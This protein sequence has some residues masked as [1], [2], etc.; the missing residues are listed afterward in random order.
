VL[1]TNSAMLDVFR[2]VGFPMT[3]RPDVDICHVTMSIAATERYR[4]RAFDR[5]R[6]AAASSMRALFEP[7]VVA[8]IG[9]SH[10]RGRIG[11][12]IFHNLRAS[13]FVGVAIPVNP[14][15]E[16][17]EGIKAYHS[18]TDIPGP[19]DLAVIAVPCEHVLPVADDCIAKGV[20]G[21]VVIS[22]G[23]G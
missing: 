20:K 16:S 8:V 3:E 4:D 18:I 23:F 13:G 15:A 22:A 12:E 14:K 2:D 7:V 10:M 9:A 21:L 5:T 11:S 19:V 6:S 17:I 1:R